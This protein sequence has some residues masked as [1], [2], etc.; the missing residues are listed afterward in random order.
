MARSERLKSEVASI[1][2]STW[3]DEVRAADRRYEPGKFTTFAAYRFS[4]TKEDGG[5]MHR[6]VVFRGTENIP[7][8]PFN[9]LMSRDPE[10]LW[11]WM[12]DLREKGR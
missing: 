5:S 11:D 7:T 4:T 2:R 3:A 8:M 10:A 9:R 12:E 1:M 6:N